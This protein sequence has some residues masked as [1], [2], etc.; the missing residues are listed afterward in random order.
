MDKHFVV[1]GDSYAAGAELFSKGWT[2]GANEDSSDKINFAQILGNDYT[3]VTNYS[4]VGCSLMGYLEQLY[5]F[6]EDYDENKSYLVLVMLTQH[7][8]EYV[9]DNDKGWVNVYPR[10]S[11]N[12]NSYTQVEKRVYD[13][14]IYPQS[15]VLNWY[16][17]VSLI[18]NY[19]CS[20]NNMLDIYIEQFNK[21]PYNQKLEF[22]IN[23]K[24]IYQTPVIKELFFKEGNDTSQTLDWT[25]FLKSEN[26]KK[27]YYPN[28]HP[29]KDG[30]LLIANRVKEIINE[31]SS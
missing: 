12:D 4:T 14:F 1:L 21:S 18:Q 29:N 6:N 31:Y 26:Y 11:Q 13:N 19:C 22:I 28:F 3:S 27:Y 24:K 2:I 30:H 15:G 7:N 9:Y 8:R 5:A 20:K 10:I 16:K 23:R 25:N 17:A